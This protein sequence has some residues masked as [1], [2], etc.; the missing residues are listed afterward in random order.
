[1]LIGYPI[2]ETETLPLVDVFALMKSFDCPDT[3]VM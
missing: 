3:E 1:M 2:V